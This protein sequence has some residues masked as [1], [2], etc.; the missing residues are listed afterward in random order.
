MMVI[1]LNSLAYITQPMRRNYKIQLRF[2]HLTLPGKPAV[3][4]H[5]PTFPHLSIPTP[6]CVKEVSEV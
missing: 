3:L 1:L 2:V 5:S 4:P 6:Q